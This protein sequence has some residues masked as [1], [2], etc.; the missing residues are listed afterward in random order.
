LNF[1]R[2]VAS[3]MLRRAFRD[4]LKI[5]WSQTRAISSLP[6]TVAIALALI[7][8]LAAGRPLAGMVV[9]SGA[10]SV[11]FGAFQR[12]GRS[13]VM[14]MLWASVGM[15]VCTAAGSVAT[16]SRSALLFV[17]AAVGFSYGMMTVVSGGT[18]WISLQCAIF[19]LV[20]TGYPATPMLVITRALLIFAGGILQ[21][22]LVVFFRR[23]HVDLAAGVA[24]DAF[25]GLGPT[26]RTLRAS[27]TWRSTEFRYALRLAMTLIVST[28]SAH[29]FALS[30]GYWIPMTALFVL[31]T[32][33]HE[34]LTRGLARMAGTIVGAGLATLLVSLLRPGPG[35]LVL[36]IVL[37]AWLSYSTVLVSYGTLSASVTA[38]IACLLAFGGLPEPDVAVHRIANTCAGGAIALVASAVAAQYPRHPR[39]AAK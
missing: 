36:L 24:P 9:A 18:A 30:N 34:T 1:S 11:G 13:R 15:M 32:D 23:L 2:G 21:L 14:P 16:H 25:S 17:A 26:L 27:L 4:I 10:M 7:G 8:G 22:L 31:R 3:E 29:Y 39:T 6:C 5:D 19:T 38:Y 37:F 28:I 33:L 35:A 12:L 20:A